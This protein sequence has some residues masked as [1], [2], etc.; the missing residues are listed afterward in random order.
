[1]DSIDYPGLDGFLGTRATFMLDV[2]VLA[3]AVVVVVL[4]WS[5]Y[6][7]KYRR[8]YELHKWVQVG[9]GV[10]LLAAVI[11]FEVD[12]RLHGWEERAAG[13]LGGHARR[14]VWIAL[15]IH[16]VF[17]VTAADP[18]A[19]GHHPSTAQF[20]EPARARPTQPVPPPL[21]SHRRDRHVHH[22]LHRLDL[23]LSGVRPLGA[24]R[25][26]IGDCRPR[27][28][29]SEN[30]QSG[31]L[32]SSL[33]PSDLPPHAMPLLVVGSVAIDN[34]ETPPGRRDDLLGGSATHF[35]LRRQ[36]FHAR[37]TGGRR[38]RRLAARA[39]R[40]PRQPRHRLSP[41]SRSSRPAN[42]SAGPAATSRT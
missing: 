25:S 26:P 15:A 36:L 29:Q 14:H 31:I 39:H 7:V 23:L 3:M 33:P 4:A 11:V 42:R 27:I 20:P 38:R 16:L 10:V 28:R 30:L 2:L 19:G 22:G 24:I 41:A 5:I 34:V 40:I 17:A 21:G 18:L 1:M 35:S 37:A 13:E 32:P 12:V 6:Q 9:L 8:R